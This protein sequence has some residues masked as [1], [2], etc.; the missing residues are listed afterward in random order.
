MEPR[1]P[2][3][4]RQRILEYAFAE[5]Y[6]QGFQAAS[7]AHILSDTGLTKGALYHHFPDKKTLGLAVVD[8]IIAGG[9]N[10]SVLDPIRS[11]AR[12]TQA[13][14][15]V[16]AERMKTRTEEQVQ[17]GCPLNNL[18]QEMSPIDEDFRTH[19][20]AILARWQGTFE[21]ALRKAQKAG[22]V[23]KDVN[24]RSA[25]LFM[26]SAWEGCTGI[27]KNMQSPEAYSACMG[28]LHSFVRSLM[29]TP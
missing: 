18:M 7:I 22:D 24:C 20:N 1:Q 2:D 14:L 15:D 3:L 16:L 21:D 19:L 12:P 11:A 4:T 8:E 6:R 26:V 23:R 25:A 29:T 28:Q 27:A 13:L 5:I 17:L 9:L 10:E